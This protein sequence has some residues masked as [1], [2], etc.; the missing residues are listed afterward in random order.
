MWEATLSPSSDSDLGSGLWFDVNVVKR[1]CSEGGAFIIGERLKVCTVCR[2][3]N[4][5]NFIFDLL[6]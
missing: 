6:P 2:I 1:F 3:W 4:H 5:D